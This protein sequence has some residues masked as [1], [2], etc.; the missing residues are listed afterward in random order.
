MVGHNYLFEE[1]DKFPLFVNDQCSNNKSE[2]KPPE[3]SFLQIKNEDKK[4]L[5]YGFTHKTICNHP[6][7][8]YS[9]YNIIFT[10]CIVDCFDIA[11]MSIE[12]IANE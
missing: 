5:D 1:I 2:S 3:E 9:K 6:F 4:P 8:I 12:L 7:I 11:N 10:S